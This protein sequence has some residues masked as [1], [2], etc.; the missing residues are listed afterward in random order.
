[1]SFWT[2]P[3]LHRSRMEILKGQ[4]SLP[5]RS[6]ITARSMLYLTGPLIR[7]WA[8]WSRNLFHLAAPSSQPWM[9]ILNTTRIQLLLGLWSLMLMHRWAE[10][11]NGRLDNYHPVSVSSLRHMWRIQKTSMRRFFLIGHMVTIVWNELCEN[12]ISVIQVFIMRIIAVHC[13]DCY[14]F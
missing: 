7:T 10:A 12:F 3:H 1:M 11:L 8:Q 13:R 2:R 5:C 6:P 9:E 14:I 4:T